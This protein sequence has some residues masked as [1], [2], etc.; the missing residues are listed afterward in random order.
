MFGENAKNIGLA[1][2]EEKK[3]IPTT[4]TDIFTKKVSLKYP[5]TPVSSFQNIS[6]YIKLQYL[7]QKNPT[8]ANVPK[9]ENYLDTVFASIDL[10]YEDGAIAVFEKNTANKFNPVILPDFK[11]ISKASVF[12]TGNNLVT[13]LTTRTFTHKESAND[14]PLISGDISTNSTDVN[15]A[16]IFPKNAVFIKVD[17]AV[18]TDN[19]PV[20]D[21][22]LYNKDKKTT[23]KEELFILFITKL[24]LDNLINLANTEGL[25]KLHKRTIVLSNRTSET[26]DVQ[27]PYIKYELKVQGLL[28]ASGLQYTTSGSGIFV[29]SLSERVFSSKNSGTLVQVEAGLPD[30]GSLQKWFHIGKY[31]YSAGTKSV[32]YE[33]NVKRSVTIKGICRF[34]ADDESD[35]I[36]T[37]LTAY[38]LIVIVHGNGHDYRSYEK[39]C[40]H[41]AKNGFITT[42][43]HC[44]LGMEAKGRAQLAYEHIKQIK[45]HFNSS[46][47]NNIG[48]MGHSRGGEAVVVAAN[49]I[50]DPGSSIY[51]DLSAIG[52]ENLKAVISLAPTD[53][54]PKVT[55][56][57]TLVTSI[58]RETLNKDVPFFV[59]Y[60]SMDYD[61]DGF[62][63]LKN[64]TVSG[65]DLYLLHEDILFMPTGFALYDRAIGT[66]KSKSMAFVIKASHNGFVTDNHDA[67]DKGVP[68]RNLALISAQKNFSYTYM[69]AFFRMHLMNE[70]FWAQ[71]FTGYYKPYSVGNVNSLHQF[72]VYD[73]TQKIIIDNMESQ[74]DWFTSSSGNNV[75]L[76]NLQNQGLEIITQGQLRRFDSDLIAAISSEGTS[77]HQ[78]RGIR[79]Y[80][81]GKDKLIFETSNIDLTAFGY[82]SFRISSGVRFADLKGMKAGLIDNSNSEKYYDLPT[83][84]RPHVRFNP[85]NVGAGSI[86][87]GPY[88]GVSGDFIL[89]PTKNAMQTLR[90]PLIEFSLQGVDLTNIIG[91]VFQFPETSVGKVNI[92]D[93]TITN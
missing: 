21:L 69:N 87:K 40:N 36:S 79:V 62:F 20:L 16:Q 41:L 24:E 75:T 51:S 26:D 9:F 14:Y 91:I 83:I 29:H 76:N 13:F 15:Q 52:M 54:Y 90:I 46:V 78:T 68:T 27:I 18:G 47:E 70:P 37:V 55:R 10:A 49:A 45:T 25:S 58:I 2:F 6:Y 34:P 63:L 48:I 61:I 57:G 11:F 59:I 38:P 23:K 60:G 72:D 8:S 81:K 30:A 84:L 42:S 35:S 44:D 17:L 89:S 66:T 39:I 92:D 56:S 93:V 12:E 74:A 50:L 28:Q 3:L 64:E 67:T 4:L 7:R 31:N 82:L 86:S 43:I 71:Y 5:V 73:S 33:G 80:W 65:D 19:I 22:P 1:Q 88:A 77:P 85:D 32:Y 53:Q